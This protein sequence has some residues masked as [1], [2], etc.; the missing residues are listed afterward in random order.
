MTPVHTWNIGSKLH[1]VNFSDDGSA[2]FAYGNHPICNL[3]EPESYEQL[4]TGLRDVCV[5]VNDI[6]ENGVSVGG[7]LYRVRFCLGGKWKFLTC[8]CGLDSASSTCACIWCICSKDERRG[9][10]NEVDTVG[11]CILPSISALC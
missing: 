3:K 10:K 1:V 4:K 11:Y 9:C 8:V 5:D 7:E 2:E 6:S